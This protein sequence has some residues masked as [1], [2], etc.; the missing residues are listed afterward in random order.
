MNTIFSKALREILV[1][2]REEAIRLGNEFISSEHLFLGILR[3]GQSNAIRIL[4][5]LLVDVVAVREE[6]ETQ[7][8]QESPLSNQHQSSVPFNKEAEKILKILSLE[9]KILSQPKAEAEH[10]LLAI[11]KNKSS[12]VTKILEQSH[13]SYE[14]I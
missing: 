6:I 14:D 9:A 8:R 13:I 10:L 11:L 12:L 4:E 5:T 1:Y 7:L 2:S 3:E